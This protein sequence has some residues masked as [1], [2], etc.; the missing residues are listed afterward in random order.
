MTQTEQPGRGGGLQGAGA[1]IADGGTLVSQFTQVVAATEAQAAAIARAV[2]DGRGLEDGLRRSAE[3]ASACTA[4]VRQAFAYADDGKRLVRDSSGAAA[5]VAEAIGN[6]SAHFLAVAEAT[7][8]IRGVIR[9]IH[10]IAQQT[11]LLALNGAIEAA[12][13]GE[14]GK[15]F[16]V[17]AT[18][19]RTLAQRS[20]D[21]SAE[22]S[23]TIDRITASTAR[24][25]AAMGEARKAVE[26][27][28][29]LSGEA[30]TAID[31]VTRS[32]AEAI[33]AAQAVET[34]AA[35]QSGLAAGIVSDM[36][37]LGGLIATGE[38]AVRRCND[39]LRT[40]IGRVT[41]FKH[42]A[43]SL[44]GEADPWQAVSEAIE[45]MRVNNVLIMNSRSVAE[46][47]PC[48]ERV[49]AA[50]RLIDRHWA[51]LRHHPALTAAAA[52][53]FEQALD[54]YRASRDDALGHAR[55]GD[56]ATVRQKVPGAVRPCYQA[57]K[58]CLEQLPRDAHA[59]S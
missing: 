47:A 35:R 40:V 46:A 52:Q 14:T 19:V 29:G 27:S 26:D 39:V 51:R 1:L 9:M 57:L 25:Q 17:V 31:G 5:R 28:V 15:G 21:A 24:V 13:A 12:R 4:F 58:T 3:D 59:V 10:G 2:E 7:D 50:D 11:I 6:V 20:R 49:A 34:D 56:F 48:L 53:A 43:E 30:A 8:E 37:G 36:E 44:L 23:G 16:A 32:G 42:D 55:S 41:A 54:R 33:T 18:E 45:E 22:I 38:Q